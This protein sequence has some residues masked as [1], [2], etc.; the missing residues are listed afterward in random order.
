MKKHLL[1]LFALVLFHIN[2]LLAQ[3]AGSPNIACINTMGP[4]GVLND[5]IVGQFYSDT[6][7]FWAPNRVDASA[8][9]GGLFDSLDFIELKILNVTGLPV[10][11]TW[12][13][14]VGNCTYNPQ[15]SGTL[16]S[17]NFCGTPF[18]QETY[19]VTIT[20]KGTVS[21]PIGNQSQ[22]QAFTLPLEIS[23]GSNNTSFSFSPSQG[24]DS[25]WVNFSP[26]LNFPLP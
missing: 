14:N 18:S 11:I 13:C 2:I 8:Q 4:C 15:P 10:G 26:L 16:A 1:T 23:L 7:T 19:T 17:I 22:N 24:C 21:T 6:I 5:G 25:I 12:N 20:V 9:S 3:C